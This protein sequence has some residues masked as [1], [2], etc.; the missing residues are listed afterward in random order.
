[1]HISLGR[2]VYP[3][4]RQ[5]TYGDEDF[6]LQIVKEGYAALVLEQREGV[7]SI[8]LGYSYYANHIT[9]EQ[10]AAAKALLKT[11]YYYSKLTDYEKQELTYGPILYG[12]SSITPILPWD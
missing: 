7:T 10:K 9:D 12:S 4:D 6:A 8:L 3:N 1:M 2:M 11:D 5:F